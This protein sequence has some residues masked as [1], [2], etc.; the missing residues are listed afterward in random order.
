MGV[1]VMVRLGA[2]AYA[3]PVGHV[4]E[5]AEL[6]QVEP[7]PRAR[8]ELLGVRN[9]RGQILPVIDLAQ[10]LGVPHAAPPARL[11]VAEAS[12][13]RAGFAIGDVT[14]VTELPDPDEETDSDLLVGAALSHGGLVGVIDTP[15]VFDALDGTR[16]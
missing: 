7:V 3:M 12:G 6:G 1:Y 11:L 14:G 2:E 9:L 5:V 16:R 10:L 15:R 8:P 4:R 13:R